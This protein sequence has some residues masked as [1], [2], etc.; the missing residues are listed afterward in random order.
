ML[1]SD[2]EEKYL[3]KRVFFLYP[4]SVMHEEL[5]MEIIKNEYEAYVLKDHNKTLKLLE[6]YND[7]IIFINI[8]SELKEEEWE[9]YIRNIMSNPATMNVKIGI[10]SYNDDETLAEKYLMELMLP[11]GFIKLKL[12]FEESAK[13]ILKVLEANEA[14]GMRK[15]LRAEFEGSQIA[16]FNMKINNKYHNGF[17]IDISSV[18][19]AVEFDLDDDIQLPVNSQISDVQL[20]LRGKIC[21]VFGKVVGV[22]HDKKN[23]FVI[24]FD[25]SLKQIENDKIH[26]FIYVTLQN[27]LDDEIKNIKI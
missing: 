3:G 27:K 2:K 22:R 6:K 24:L 10:L 1:M 7:S 25:K 9:E 16:S 17:I 13:I 14:K 20:R 4:H 18:G 8:D 15:Y 21:M 26:K 23:I 12:G 19:M 5:I 11:C